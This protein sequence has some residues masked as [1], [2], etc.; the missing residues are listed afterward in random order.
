M[1]HAEP[2]L[3]ED[4][5]FCSINFGSSPSY[6]V[7]EDDHHLAFLDIN[8]IVKGHTL[9][10]PRKHFDVLID[11]DEESIGELFRAVAKIA[12]KVVLG[13]QA[14]GFRLIQNNGEAAA[15]VVKHVHVHIIP[16]KLG[17]KNVFL[18]RS[19]PAKEELER[20]AEEIRR[21]F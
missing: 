5:V 14:D 15:Q 18:N 20:T 1:H 13:V 2:E 21:A 8:P 10:I 12:S 7:F 16:L 11:M 9:V 17:Q 4:C 6:K 19:K 3:K